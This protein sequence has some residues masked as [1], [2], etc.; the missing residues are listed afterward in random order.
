MTRNQFMQHKPDTEE[1]TQ[2]VTEVQNSV[3][4]LLPLDTFS[5]HSDTKQL[6][7]CL[8]SA[9]RSRGPT[10]ATFEQLR[11]RYIFVLTLTL[12]FNGFFNFYFLSIRTCIHF[13]DMKARHNYFIIQ[14]IL[15][16]NSKP[17]GLSSTLPRLRG[18]SF[19]KL[20]IPKLCAT[21]TVPQKYRVL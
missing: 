6:V 15:D 2:I 11:C 1:V 3:P 20:L 16:G 14:K 18:E 4:V 12:H 8:S 7:C 10:D 9:P 17:R 19:T 21:I 5:T 13:Q